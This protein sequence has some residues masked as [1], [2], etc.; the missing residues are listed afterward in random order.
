MLNIQELI[1]ILK[2]LEDYMTILQKKNID[3]GDIEALCCEVSEAIQHKLEDI[4]EKE[5]YFNKHK[6]LRDEFNFIPLTVN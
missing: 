6:I 3:T 4:Q 1:V 5:S 2:H